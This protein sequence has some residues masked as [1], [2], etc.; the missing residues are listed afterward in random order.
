ME[1]NIP[2]PDI[3]TA[4]SK[5]EAT[6][7]NHIQLILAEKRTSLSMMRTGIAVMALPLGVLGLLISTSR[8]Y[9]AAA[10]WLLLSVVLVLCLG[11]SVLGCFLITR[12]VL[13]IRA[14]DHMIREIKR[15]S[16]TLANY[17]G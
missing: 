8:F 17:L 16:P 3:L 15:L 13:R 2:S 6:V 9:N 14:Y 10:N 7:I 12:S 5:A 1:N 11:L 4:L